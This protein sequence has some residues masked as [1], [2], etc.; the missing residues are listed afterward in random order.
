[1]KKIFVLPFVALFLISNAFAQTSDWPNKPVKIIV[2]FT[3]GGA[4]DLT[5]RELAKRFSTK[6]NQSFVVENLPGAGGT[7]GISSFIKSK[8]DGYTLLVA[9]TG[10]LSLQPAIY[11]N[12][13]YDPA[14]D[15]K[16]ISQLTSAPFIL[17]VSSDFPGKTAK[18]LSAE[19]KANPKKYNYT[20][21]GN[22]TLV[23]L[24]GEMFS[25]ASGANATHVSYKGGPE[26]V[27]AVASKDALYTITN[28]SNAMPLLG[29]GKLKALATSGS[30]R[31]GGLADIPTIAENGFP[32]FDSTVWVGLF[33]P[34]NIPNNIVASLNEAT[35]QALADPTF[36]S[37]MTA[38]GDEPSPKSPEEFSQFIAK[39]TVKWGTIA[40]NA[41][42]QME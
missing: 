19:L 26:S 23:H 38:N 40:R 29:S 22:G 32:N 3:P 35:R 16:P 27:L 28:I 31:P 36:V 25:Q 14:T 12:L 13:P 18:D 37:K 34:K 1:M 21:T 39:E 15:L 5:A 7:V 41:N 9:S 11:K 30:K 8:P 10:Q 33:G 4:L 42:V 17:V 2:P 20:S 6:Y 24:T